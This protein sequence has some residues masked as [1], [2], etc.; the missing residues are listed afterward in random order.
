MAAEGPPTPARRRLSIPPAPRWQV[1]PRAPDGLAVLADFVGPAWEPYGDVGVALWL[2]AREVQLWTLTPTFARASAE[3]RVATAERFAEAADAVP[4]LA[5]AWET[6]SLLVTASGSID[7]RALAVACHDVYAWAEKRSLIRTAA[8]FAELAAFL[9]EDDPAF[10]EDT[11]WAW[12]CAGQ[13]ERSEEWHSRAFALAVHRRNR[14]QA[15]RSLIGRATLEKDRARSKVAR[16]FY[17]RAVRR[18]LRSGKRRLAAYAQHHLFALVAETGGYDDALQEARH[19][20]DLC[21][22]L[23]PCLPHLMHNLAYMLMRNRHYSA[24]YN[25]VNRIPAVVEEETDRAVIWSTVA[26]AA[27]ALGRR[28]EFERAASCATELLQRSEQPAAAAWIHLGYGRRHL[29]DWNGAEADGVSA[30]SAALASGEASLHQEADQLLHELARRVDAPGELPVPDEERLYSLINRFN[31][32]FRRWLAPRS[33]RAEA[34]PQPE[35][36]PSSKRRG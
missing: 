8:R 1:D 20:L 14:K 35:R 15:I 9:D 26:W 10:A 29:R 12:R 30:V 5:P 24:A 21:P 3:P 2:A 16:T 19:A 23:D 25:L 17:E 18:A 4:E 28:S 11:G 31:V 36:T 32:R 27:A 34:S 33:R 7:P 22:I 6:F 13:H